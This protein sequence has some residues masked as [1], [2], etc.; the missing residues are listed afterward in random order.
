MSGVVIIGGGQAGYQTAASLRT[1]G[2]DGPVTLIGDEPHAPYQRPPLSKAFVLGK[3]DLARVLLRP[4]PYYSEHRIE[5]LA[6][7][8]VVEIERTTREVRLKSGRRLHYDKLVLAL[9]A[10]NRLLPIPGAE[11][12][13]VRYLRTLGEAI[14][15]K[16]RL[17]SASSVAVIGGGFVGLEIAAS[18]RILGK[19]VTLLE[20]LPRLMARAV[21]PVISEFV[22]AA[23]V[24]QGTE[25]VLDARVHEIRGDSG[26]ARRVILAD[27]RE[28]ETDLVIVGVGVTPNMELAAEAGL[29]VNNGIVADMHL[30]TADED[31][32]A[33][34]DCAQ[35]PSAFACSRVRL[36]SVQNAVDHGVCVARTIAG[37]P[38]AYSAVPWFW[39]DQFDLRLQMA[40]LG[41]GHDRQVLRGDPQAG[42]F[43]VFHFRGGKLCSVDSVNRPLDHMAARKILGSSA[44]L[45][46]EQAADES[47][48]LKAV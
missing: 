8:R 7:E 26:R 13:G 38:V 30:R 32:F 18:A 24:A 36:E 22:H 47:F 15:L 2:H 23:H 41:N 42:K 28:I 45:T 40:G 5:L 6:G 35:Y 4:E 17:E 3:H 9:G 21:A 1:E 14:E 10:R 33:I 34:G 31:I 20:A 46:P 25:I 12:E 37:K 27:G 19:Q 43:S 29:P 48:N 44:A 16:Q 39:S 11:L